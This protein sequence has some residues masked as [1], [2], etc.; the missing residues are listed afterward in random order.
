M[1]IDGMRL[2]SGM[3]WFEENSLQATNASF[4]IATYGKCIY[5]ID[6]EKTILERGDFLLIKAGV[7]YYGKSVPTVFHEKFVIQLSINEDILF[8]L[9]LLFT[10]SFVKSKAGCFDLILE[11]LRTVWKE[12]QDAIPYCSF[13]AYSIVLDAFSLWCRELDRG[14]EATITL[15]HIEKMKAYIGQYYRGKVTKDELGACIGRSPNH[16]AA[17]FRRVTGQTIS[18]Y[19]HATRI[20]TA[21]YM[22]KESLLTI[23]EI[24]EYLGY[25]DVSYFQRIF[26]RIIGLSPT[27]YLKIQI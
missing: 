4:V 27:H 14:D 22:L 7:H 16:A 19:V 3:S 2:D 26:K 17:L 10:N 1:S 11:R 24:A 25:S 21:T 18:D 15:Q 9:P 20:R 12:W 23:S 5:W 8:A 13:R 6:G